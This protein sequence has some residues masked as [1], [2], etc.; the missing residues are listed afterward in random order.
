MNE[1]LEAVKNVL[2][3]ACLCATLCA[4]CRQERTNDR[5]ETQISA[6]RAVSME[7]QEAACRT[8]AQ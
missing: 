2:V 6:L 5:I 1:F 7:F 3:I 8:E 4:T